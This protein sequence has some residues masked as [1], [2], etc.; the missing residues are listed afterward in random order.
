MPGEPNVPLLLQSTN[1]ESRKLE[2]KARTLVVEKSSILQDPLSMM[3]DGDD[4]LSLFQRQAA[5]N[6]EEDD[7]VGRRLELNAASCGH[8]LTNGF[9]FFFHFSGWLITRNPPNISIYNRG[10]PNAKKS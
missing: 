9:F 4:P 2:S 5:E 8:K 3:L 1:F 6:M 7:E 10:R